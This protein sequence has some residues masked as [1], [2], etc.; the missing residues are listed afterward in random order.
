M[1]SV[2]SAAW[3]DVF[4]SPRIPDVMAYV[5]DTW[6]TLR[7]AYPAAVSFT[8][9]EPDLTDNL[10]EAL[11]DQDRRVLWR[12]DCDFQAE[13]WEIRRAADGTTNRLARADI[14][15]ILGAPGTPHFVLEFKKLD[16]SA[17]MRWRYCHD[18]LNRFVD[19]KY[20]VG[21]EHGA[22]CAFT[23]TPATEATAM[24]TYLSEPARA[25]AL[26]CVTVGGATAVMSPS[27]TDP[28]SSSF[29]SVHQRPLQLQ[30]SMIT[31]VHAFF[32]CP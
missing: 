14:R 13:T 7:A 26:G 32:E 16:G 12:M 2:P 31:I 5:S 22:M 27:V 30:S 29:D 1:S 28:V 8:K 18:G 11:A 17:G 3:F 21:H 19:G 15:V 10:C 4:P 23:P 24:A 20:A 25:A 6:N 9:S